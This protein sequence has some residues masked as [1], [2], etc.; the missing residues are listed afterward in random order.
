MHVATQLQRVVLFDLYPLFKV[1]VQ[2][3]HPPLDVPINSPTRMPQFL[4]RCCTSSLLLPVPSNSSRQ[5]LENLAKLNFDCFV[6]WG[7]R[8]FNGR[9]SDTATAGL[10]NLMLQGGACK[11]NPDRV[12]RFGKYIHV[13]FF[14]SLKDKFSP[15]VK[16]NLSPVS[17]LVEPCSN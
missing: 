8:H 17:A 15:A 14:N 11:V 9:Y 10:T 7:K 12:D 1:R 6:K 13:M 16:V 3:P 4:S 5:S 2:S